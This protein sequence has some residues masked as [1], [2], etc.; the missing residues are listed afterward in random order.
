M[1]ICGKNV[2]KEYLN[3]NEKINS[4]IVFENFNDEDLLN[5]LKKKTNNIKFVKKFE[6]DRI[7]KENHQG[8][9]LNIDDYKYSNLD[10]LLKDENPLIVILDHIEDPHNFGAII[11]TCEAANVTGIIIPKNRCVDV[12]ETVIRTSVGAS[13]YVK[14]VEITNIVNTIKELKSKGFW[15]VGTD[16]DGQ[17]YSSIDYKGKTCV[18]VGNEGSGMSRIVRENCDFI[19]TIPMNGKINSLNASV[20]AGIIIY[21]A[22]R[23]RNEL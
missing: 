6:L 12:N 3:T 19:A 15:I 13:K 20:A 22:V 9:I 8:I 14:I 1:R 18:I 17:D 21:E 2:A 4:A 11:R 10:E 5:K 7:T 16:M 23:I